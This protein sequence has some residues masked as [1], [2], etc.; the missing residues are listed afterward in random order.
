MSAE[1]N[2][3]RANFLSLGSVLFERLQPVI[4]QAKHNHPGTDGQCGYCPFCAITAMTEK[5]NPELVSRVM[6]QMTELLEMLKEAVEGKVPEPPAGSSKADE[7][8]ARGRHAAPDA[9]AKA[10]GLA[11]NSAAPS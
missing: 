10:E 5:N 4:E 6:G 8:A 11:S 1:S 2:D 7:D 9:A 3:V